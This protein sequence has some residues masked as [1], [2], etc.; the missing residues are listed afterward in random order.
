MCEVSS[1]HDDLISS[2]TPKSGLYTELFLPLVLSS[3]IPSSL[4]D[5]LHRVVNYG[6]WYFIKYIINFNV[7]LNWSPGS[8]RLHFVRN[9]SVGLF[10]LQEKPKS[11]LLCLDRFACKIKISKFLVKS[12]IFCKQFWK[13]II[14]KSFKFFP[15]KQTREL[16][17]HNMQKNEVKFF[18][19]IVVEGHQTWSDSTLSHKQFQG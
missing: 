15:F 10:K 7:S 13:R 6:K 19:K 4:T 16:Y 9:H 8:C 2:Q 14:C 17:I 12:A 1:R 5:K 11:G 18:L 3:D